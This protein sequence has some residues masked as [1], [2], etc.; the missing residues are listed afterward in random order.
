MRAQA[1]A[2]ERRNT[3]DGRELVSTRIVTEVAAAKGVDQ[4]ELTPL[5]DRVESDALDRV[6]ESMDDAGTVTFEYEG[7]EVSVRGDGRVEIE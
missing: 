2:Q 7:Y 5:Y 1:G 6:V 3:S 4:A